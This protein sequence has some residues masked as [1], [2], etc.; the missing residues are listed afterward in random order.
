MGNLCV[1]GCYLHGSPLAVFSAGRLFCREK[2]VA[3]PLASGLVALRGPGLG[4]AIIFDWI[5]AETPRLV[6]SLEVLSFHAR[7]DFLST[8]LKLE[9]ELS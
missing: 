8:V 9:I 6:S 1:G 3:A 7:N 2:N 5:D 4:F